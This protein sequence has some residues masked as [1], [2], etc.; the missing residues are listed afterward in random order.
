MDDKSATNVLDSGTIESLQLK[1]CLLVEAIKTSNPNKIQL[2]FAEKKSANSNS[3]LSKF[4]ANDD[5]FSSK[6]TRAWLTAEYA[7]VTRLLGI[8]LDPSSDN[9]EMKQVMRNGKQATTEV[10]PLNILN[11]VVL[12]NNELIRILVVESNTPTK[13]EKDTVDEEGR[14]K[15]AKRAGKEGDFILCKGEYIFMHKEIVS[16]PAGIDTED[17]TLEADNIETGIQANSGV[18]ADN[19]TVEAETSAF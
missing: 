11:P 17:F 4:N 19:V 7:D 2:H 16:L 1:N 5:K 14:P 3:L 10:M 12:D 9:W 13:Y 6:A 15:M 18:T 8:K